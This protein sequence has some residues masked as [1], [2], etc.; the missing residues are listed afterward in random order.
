[1]CVVI[2]ASWWVSV[3]KTARKGTVAQI[4]GD[5]TGLM[6]RLQMVGLID[7]IVVTDNLTLIAGARLLEAMKR[8]GATMIEVRQVGDL[9]ELEQRSI[10][11]HENSDRKD[12][13]PVE[14]SRIQ[15]EPASAVASH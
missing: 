9:S 8:L 2:V 12:L 10:E 13:T 15:V 5:L 4:I 3:A 6:K 14:R 11:L 7:P 1:M